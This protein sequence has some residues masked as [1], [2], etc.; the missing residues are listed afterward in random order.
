[1]AVEKRGEVNDR[2]AIEAVRKFYKVCRRLPGK[3]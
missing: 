3:L 1:M 2:V